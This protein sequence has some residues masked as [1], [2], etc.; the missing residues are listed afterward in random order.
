[1]LNNILLCLFSGMKNKLK[2]ANVSQ[3]THYCSSLTFLVLPFSPIWSIICWGGLFAQKIILLRSIKVIGCTIFLLF[4][5][6]K[7][8]VDMCIGSWVFFVIFWHILVIMLMFNSTNYTFVMEYHGVWIRSPAFIQVV[9]ELL[10]PNYFQKIFS[11]LCVT[12]HFVPC[13]IPTTS[14]TD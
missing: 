3:L 12:L 5:N 7:I 10:L 1:M 14:W 8:D 11:H 6:P 13:P 9:E 2:P 4:Y